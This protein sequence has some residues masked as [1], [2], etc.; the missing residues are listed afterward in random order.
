MLAV[1]H[2]AG[3]SPRPAILKC[4]DARIHFVTF[5]TPDLDAA[6]T[7]YRDGLGWTPLADV[8]GEILFFQAG[9]GLVLGLFEVAAF[10][11]DIGTDAPETT[12]SGVTLSHNVSSPEEVDAVIASAAA[13]GALVI[14]E[15]QP[16]SFGG[17]HGHFSDP[18]GVIWEVAHNPGWRVEPDGTVVFG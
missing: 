4:M 12:V 2:S 15:P 11:E 8:V 17:Y 5:A 9:P 6:R 14:K 1:R 3:M 13:A 18:N 7:F 16:A 10:S